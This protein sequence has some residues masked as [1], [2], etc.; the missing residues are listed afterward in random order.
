MVDLGHNRPSLLSFKVSTWPTGF[1]SAGISKTCKYVFK[2][3]IGF[4]RFRGSII[5]GHTFCKPP[6]FTPLKPQT[7]FAFF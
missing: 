6:Y 7:A 4:R 5:G 1:S 2:E 3:K